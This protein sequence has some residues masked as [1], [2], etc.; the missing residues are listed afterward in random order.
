MARKQP[1]AIDTIAYEKALRREVMAIMV[2]QKGLMKE[3]AIRNIEAMNLHK[4]EMM[5][6]KGTTSDLIRKRALVNSVVSERLQWE[7]NGT[8]LSLITTAMSTNFEQSFIGWFYE[9]GTG[10]K[11]Q[12]P[13]VGF[14][15]PNP[16]DKNPYRAFGSGTTIVS[17]S[18]SDNG[19]YWTDMGG[20]K[21]KTNSK[22]GGKPLPAFNTP[23]YKWFS[24]A[25]EETVEAIKE[26]LKEVPNRVN[27]T[28]FIEGRHIRLS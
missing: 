24:R 2:R 7:M 18:K 12:A 4:R 14:A 9:F 1:L 28:K 27:V 16:G 10:T 20:N 23:A 5:L 11:Y 22:R 8:M 6:E 13:K 26:E 19:G 3:R 21:R 25:H 17:R 15:L